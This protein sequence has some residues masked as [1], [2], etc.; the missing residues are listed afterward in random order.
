VKRPACQKTRAASSFEA[1]A[2][3]W[4]NKLMSL[5]GMT[6]PCSRSRGLRRSVVCIIA[7]N[8][9]P[10]EL[11]GRLNSRPRFDVGAVPFYNCIA[12]MQWRPEPMH[13]AQV[14]AVTNVLF[15]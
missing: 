3:G 8:V 7:T 10:R 12:R 6:A 9:A 11:L 15:D 5:A 14:A 1:H 2:S 4:R 13:G